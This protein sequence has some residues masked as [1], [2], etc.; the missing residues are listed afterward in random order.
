MK[1][2]VSRPLDRNGIRW[3]PLNLVIPSEVESL[4]PQQLVIPSEVDHSLAVDSRVEE[5]AV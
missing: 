4:T 5:P 1:I 3:R 2:V